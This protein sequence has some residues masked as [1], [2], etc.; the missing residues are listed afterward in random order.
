[1]QW[2][3]ITSYE[4]RLG[5]FTVVDEPSVPEVWVFKSGQMVWEGDS[6]HEARRWCEDQVGVLGRISGNSA[7]PPAMQSRLS[8]PQR[9]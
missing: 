7:S 9:L 4:Q 3:K 6:V 1:M 5:D 8:R 2:A